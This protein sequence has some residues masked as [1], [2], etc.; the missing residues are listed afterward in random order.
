L[1]SRIKKARPETVVLMLSMFDDRIYAERALAVGSA[2]YVCKQSRNDDIIAAL[3]AVR[4]G[5]TYLQNDT[6]QRVLN[7]KVGRPETLARSEVQL[8]SARELEI[9]TLIGQGRTTHQ[10]AE[11][12]C[13]AVSTVETYRERLKLKLNLSSG[14]EL[15]RHAFLWISNNT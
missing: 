12:L 8:L 2:G 1:V 13:I 10:I 7:R 11:E 5:K 15:A 4:D 14:N 3:R 9:F 6:L